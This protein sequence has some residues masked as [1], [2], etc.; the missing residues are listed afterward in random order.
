MSFAIHY[1]RYIIER[2]ADIDSGYCRT[3]AE[4][5]GSQMR[6]K[7][8]LFGCAFLV[9][10][11][12]G[13]PDVYCATFSDLSV[14]SI[15]VDPCNAC[16]CNCQWHAV[17]KNNGPDTLTDL[18]ALQAWQGNGVNWQVSGGGSVNQLP[19]G[20]TKTVSIT[21]A[22][23]AGYDK[24]KIGI[25]GDGQSNAE[26]VIDLPAEPPM[27]FAITNGKMTSDT[28]YT[29]DVRNTS[30]GGAWNLTIQIAAENPSNPGAWV[31]AGGMSVPCLAPN[32]VYTKTGGMPLGSK[33]FMVRVYRAGAVLAEEIF[34]F[35]QPAAPG[36]QPLSGIESVPNIKPIPKVKIKKPV[37]RKR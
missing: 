1:W 25:W 8:F 35:S 24:L 27:S 23:K 9:S 21:Y 36:A 3:Q 22:R 29:V 31:G 18:V 16:G 37:P 15:T 19:A 20:Q 6:F 33:K 10:I 5:G 28:S 30:S 11:S 12:F 4:L 26:L 2:W 7:L 32:A 13:C 14:E 34:D 17:I